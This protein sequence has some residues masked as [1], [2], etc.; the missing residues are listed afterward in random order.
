MREGRI[1]PTPTLDTPIDE[2]AEMRIVRRSALPEPVRVAQVNAFG[3]GGIN[4]VAVLEGD[5]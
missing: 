3:F 1:P 2:V 5:Q 4:A